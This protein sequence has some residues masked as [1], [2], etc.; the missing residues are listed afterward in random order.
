MFDA[1]EKGEPV[2]GCTVLGRTTDA[3]S[4]EHDFIIQMEIY[5]AGLEY[6]QVTNLLLVPKSVHF[7]LGQ[8]GCLMVSALHCHAVASTPHKPS[9]LTRRRGGRRLGNYGKQ[10]SEAL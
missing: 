1:V 9:E 2:E 7:S 3:M 5:Q 10:L 8:S 6:C 4:Q